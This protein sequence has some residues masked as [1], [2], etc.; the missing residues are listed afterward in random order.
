MMME[1]LK[2]LVFAGIGGAALTYE[3]AQEVVEN[4]EKKG[5]LSVEEGKRLKEE[6]VQRKNGSERE[7]NNHE[8]VEAHLIEMT[9]THR[10]D[11]DELERKVAELTQKV[12]E[13]RSKQ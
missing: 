8:D 7:S 3:K 12:D 5:K 11:I 10:K 9:A 13:L 2:K 4:L 1:E 6:L